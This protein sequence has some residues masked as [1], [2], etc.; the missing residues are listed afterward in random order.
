MKNINYKDLILGVDIKV[1]TSDR[2]FVT[3]V[4]FD[5]AATTPPFVSVMQKIVDFAPWY[6]SI[7][8]GKGFKS[9]Y[10]STLYDESRFIVSEFVGSDVKNNT[11]LYVK[12][13]TEAINKIS[14]RL[15]PH[16]KKNVILSSE[17]EH[18]SNDLPWRD[19]YSVYYIEI[20][21]LGRLNL[22]D[23][24]KKLDK[25]KDKI[26]LVTISGAS[27][28]TGYKN[29]IHKIARLVHKYN[30]LLL[31][32][33]AQLAPHCPIDMKPLDHPEHI[34]FLVFSAHKMYAPFGTGVLIGPK[35]I[36]DSGEPDYKGGGT[37]DIVTKNEIFWAEPP[38]K[39]EAGT[40]NV[41]GVI[42][43]VESIKVLTLI[44]MK[45]IEDHEK[46][47]TSYA[48]R[49]MKNIGDIILYADCKNI[50]DRLSIIPFNIVGMHHEVCAKALS[51]EYGVAVRNGCFCAQPYIQK[52]LHVDKQSLDKI[53][54]GTY[55]PSPGMVRISFGLY[56]DTKEIDYF[57][58]CVKDIIKKREY[59]NHKYE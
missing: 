50:N 1:P 25:Y 34:D 9:Q 11:V 41:I 53:I 17:M 56:N 16:S 10:S 42:A 37:V 59:Y 35:Y 48:I 49:N 40:P 36:F 47:L 57:I 6:S 27:N 2:K 7:H 24:E 3:G 28:V 29:P 14:N 8:R 51:F 13:T 26:R 21:E 20:D 58:S 23:L 39:D 55:G 45:N 54:N 18:H 15:C 33:A 4:N 46:E 44:G 43:L 31:V 22:N 38:D 32:D 52:L 12:N 30:V 5:N 19:N